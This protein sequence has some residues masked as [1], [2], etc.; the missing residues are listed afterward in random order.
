[1]YMQSLLFPITVKALIQV[2][3][4]NLS[5]YQALIE[6]SNQGPHYSSSKMRIKSKI[7]RDQDQGEILDSGEVQVLGEDWL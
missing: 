7:V 1:M 2:K 6:N 3:A 4:C 5:I